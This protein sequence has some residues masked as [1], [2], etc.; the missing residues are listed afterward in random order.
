MCHVTEDERLVY[1]PNVASPPRV[2]NQSHLPAPAQVRLK[3]SVMNPTAAR[4]IKV[5]S[6]AA[7]VTV[8]VQDVLADPVFEVLPVDGVPF[9][10]GGVYFG[11]VIEGE[12]VD[13]GVKQR[14]RRTN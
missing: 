9:L 5:V 10:P 2:E 7:N 12:G 6:G 8:A 11:H 14:Q 13:R 1:L 4:A 3:A